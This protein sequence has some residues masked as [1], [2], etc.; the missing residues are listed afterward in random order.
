MKR[1]M[2]MIPRAMV[3]PMKNPNRQ[4]IDSSRLWSSA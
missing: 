4:P 1:R 2:T 3:A